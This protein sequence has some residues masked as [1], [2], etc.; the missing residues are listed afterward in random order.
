ME[1]ARVAVQMYTLRDECEKDFPGTLKKIAELGFD[2]VELAGF[3]GLSAERIKHLLDE[4]NLKAASSHVP[5]EQIEQN[6]ARVIED[7]KTLGC[8][9]VVIPYLDSESRT[10]N[11]YKE[12]LK[13]IDFAGSKLRQE[14]LTLCYHNHDFELEK[15]EDGRTALTTLFDDA[16]KEYIKSE[17]DIYWLTKAGENPVDWMTRYKDRTPLVHLKDMTTDEEQFFAELGTGGVDI[18]SILKL[19]AEN[20]VKWWIIEQD[21][22]RRSPLES[23]EISINYLK[24]KRK[25]INR[26]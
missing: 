16:N 14:G 26:L 3:Y 5:L 4:L 19:E 25:N 22:C 15:L 23:I 10:D 18:D 9:Y 17:F 20:N 1:R 13:T 2:G 11:G 8:N 6:L 24:E 21:V 12:L 7:H